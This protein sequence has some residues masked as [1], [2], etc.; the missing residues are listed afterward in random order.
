MPEAFREGLRD[1]D[2]RGGAVIGRE[3]WL[4]DLEREGL[5]GCSIAR[6]DGAGQAA[7]LDQLP[8]DVAFRDL[9]GL[10][11]RGELDRVLWM[12]LGVKI[13]KGFPPVRHRLEMGDR[14]PLAGHDQF[15]GALVR[16]SNSVPVHGRRAPVGRAHARPPLAGDGRRFVP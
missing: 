15:G 13:R 10:D 5:S 3:E 4:A 6:R 14:N 7:E 11:Q 12:E 16:C 1:L 9:A 8:I 2:Q